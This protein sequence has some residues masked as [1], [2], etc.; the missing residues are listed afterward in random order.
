MRSTPTLLIN[1]VY[2]ELLLTVG[3]CEAGLYS[4]LLGWKVYASGL[5]TPYYPSCSQQ[6]PPF[7]SLSLWIWPLWVP[8]KSNSQQTTLE[9]D[10]V[11]QWLK[12]KCEGFL[13]MQCN[14][15]IKEYFSTG[16]LCRSYVICLIPA[17][18]CSRPSVFPMR[19]FTPMDLLA[20]SFFQGLFLFFFQAL[21]FVYNDV[22]CCL[23]RKLLFI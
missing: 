12:G 16:L 8:I 3:P 20:G 21:S 13:P 11:L 7:F 1:D 19:C 22:P 9:G 15:F 6:D 18:H 4:I 5:G 23:S 2:N 14:P 17:L 10:L